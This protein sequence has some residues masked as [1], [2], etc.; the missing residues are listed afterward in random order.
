ML[1]YIALISLFLAL[2][3]GVVVNRK[4]IVLWFKRHKR[5]LAGVMIAS[6][7][8]AAGVMLLPVGDEPFNSTD[9]LGYELL[10]DGSVFHM[11]N[12]YDSY[13]FNRS[14]GIQ[15]SNHYEEYWTTNVLMVGYYSGEDWNLLYRV[16]E[17]SGFNEILDCE[18]DDYINVTL[19]KDLSY[20][21]YDFRLAIRYHLKPFDNDLTII[22]YIKNLGISIPFD[23]GFGWEMKDIQIDANEENDMI[24]FDD[25]AS[26]CT[27]YSLHNDSL[28][29]LDS[30]GNA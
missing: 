28:D 17:L 13:Y 8:L 1:A 5:G 11:W 24:R 27:T 23:I 20:G 4:K 19:W 16:D 30:I 12:N 14:N 25:N 3:I 15:F 29:N 7:V 21:S 10:D 18:T 26:S 9:N 22:P 2:L 6:S